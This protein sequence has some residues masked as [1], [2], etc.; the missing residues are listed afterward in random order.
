[1]ATHNFFCSKILRI[2]ITVLMTGLITAAPLAANSGPSEVKLV[3]TDG[4]YR[5][6]VNGNVFY[7][8]GAGCEYGTIS[9]LAGSGANA[10]RTWRVNTSKRT[11]VE[12]LDEAQRLGLMVFMG[13]DMKAERKGFD[14][15]DKEAVKKQYERVISEVEALKNHPALLG[16]LIGNELNLFHK[17]PA[18][19]DA[20]EEIAQYI[21]KNDP[22]HVVSTPLAGIGKDVIAEIKKRTP[23]IDFISIQMY[24]DI[25]NLQTRIR[26]AEWDDP[27][28]VTEWGA[29]GHWEVTQTEWK[30]AIEQTSTEKAAAFMER[31]KKAILAD[32]VKCIGSFV[33]LWGQK[34]EQTPTWYGM[35][36]EE[37][38]KTETVDAMHKI[39]TGSWPANRC[40]AISQVSI[41]GKGRYDNVVIAPAST[42]AAAI[43]AADVDNDAIEYTYEILPE[44]TDKKVGGD[45]E[46]RPKAVFIQKTALATLSI[47]APAEGGAYRLFFYARDIQGNCATA[48]IPFFV[49]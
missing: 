10:F 29:T 13:L 5:L 24:G 46:A 31:Y 22:N 45:W 14:Y 43:E 21:K 8:N 17:N 18:V 36:T 48:N 49:K 30:V 4:K 28:M 16:W 20:V 40:P 9:A 38:E 12:I 39:W 11:G 25:I 47:P 19:W 2:I 7:I 26:E 27:Y 23:S 34:Q 37:G 15:S 41:N 3:N 42:I 33:F 32:S 6:T 44:S 35:F 1:M